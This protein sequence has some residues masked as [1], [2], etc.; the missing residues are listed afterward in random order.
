M[1]RKK[2]NNIILHKANVSELNVATLLKGTSGLLYC[3]L[4]AV[5]AAAH[6]ILGHRIDCDN[7]WSARWFSQ[8]TIGC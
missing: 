7:N 3:E 2:S 8:P 4:S 1:K 5:W 6:L